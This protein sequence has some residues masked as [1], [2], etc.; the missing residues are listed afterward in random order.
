MNFGSSQCVRKSCDI[1]RLEFCFL[2][3]L[4]ACITWTCEEPNFTDWM[5]ERQLS[6]GKTDGKR[7][8]G[9]EH[10]S[11]QLANKAKQPVISWGT[12]GMCGGIGSWEGKGQLS[13]AQWFIF[14]LEA[15][16]TTGFQSHMC[17]KYT[18]THACMHTDT[19]THSHWMRIKAYISHHRVFIPCYFDSG[20]VSVL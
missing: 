13:E 4:I 20:P 8:G 5:S 11:V 15:F 1:S 3:Y 18:P 10:A 9:I 14:P 7:K 6:L 16:F 19:Y 12:W 17:V 2:P